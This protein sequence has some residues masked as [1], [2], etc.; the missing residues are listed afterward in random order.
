MVFLLYEPLHLKNVSLP[1]LLNNKYKNLAFYSEYI[2][3]LSLKKSL[4][5][6]GLFPVQLNS[7]KLCYNFY[8]SWRLLR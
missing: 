5:V 2:M 7:F 1:E 4:K 3:V 6:Q 8:T